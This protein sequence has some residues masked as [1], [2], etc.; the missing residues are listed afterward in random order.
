MPQGKAAWPIP[1]SA[2]RA[3]QRPGQGSTQS[4]Q[5]TAGAAQGSKP[6]ARPA[7]GIPGAAGAQ[8]P[9]SAVE[10]SAEE[11]AVILR[12]GGTNAQKQAKNA[13]QTAGK[14]GSAA[15][16]QTKGAKASAQENAAE[17]TGRIPR[18]GD[19]NSAPVASLY[20]RPEKDA[21]AGAA[22]GEKK[23]EDSAKG[24]KPQKPGEGAKK[25]REPEPRTGAG[26]AVLLAVMG[27]V[28]GALVFIGFDQLW[29]SGLSRILVGVLAIAVTGIMVG[30]VHALRTARDGVSMSLAAVVG[31]LMTFGPYI[32][33]MLQG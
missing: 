5:S 31:L 30:V 33:H 22:S 2:R 12:V 16:A 11:T 1:D 19:K 14:A 17:E 3:G 27:V 29:S 21:E 15:G 18:V 23:S 10:P 8:K 6:G 32:P 13:S 4:T 9:V 25:K 26:S 24:K 28:L 20:Q 7:A